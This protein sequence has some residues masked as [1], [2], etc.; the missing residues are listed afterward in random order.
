MSNHL[1][2]NRTIL[3]EVKK[4]LKQYPLMAMIG[5]RQ[6]GKTTFLRKVLKGYRYISLENPDH[7][8]FAETDT[9]NFL[10]QYNDKVIFDEAQNVP[11]L[12]SF[13]QGIVDDNQIMGQF[14][15]SG[16]QN[17]NLME[18]IT[19]SLAG[20]ISIV[21]LFPFDLKEM[22]AANWLSK[23]LNTVMYS[24]FYPA[25]FQRKANIDRYYADY[26]STYVNRD[27]SQLANVQ[28][29][30]LF[31]RF[32]KLCATRA[33]QLLNFNNLAKD[34]GVSHTTARN[35]LSLLET[36]FIIYRLPPYYN[37]FSKRMIKSN[38]LY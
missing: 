36:S 29:Q 28:D 34:A 4:V 7:R 8:K 22:N 26:L 30:Q 18:K 35:W 3:T 37:N 9:Q 27:V 31:K 14:I 16:S 21:S 6:S 33:G 2:N 19:Q 1:A 32:I 11:K 15:L 24:G 10:K 13:L 5:P 12:F 25:I 23:D 17:F 20:R 38:K